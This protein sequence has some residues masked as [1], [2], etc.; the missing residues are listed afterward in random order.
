MRGARSLVPGLAVGLTTQFG[1]VTAIAERPV[2]LTDSQLEQITAAGSFSF[3]EAFAQG[4]G[5]PTASTTFTDTTITALVGG[6]SAFGSAEALAVGADVSASDAV[7]QV[8]IDTNPGAHVVDATAHGVGR[9]MQISYAET[10]GIATLSP[11]E[12][13]AMG[14]AYGIGDPSTTSSLTAIETNAG[15]GT[16]EAVGM[17]D[18]LGSDGSPNMSLTAVQLTPGERGGGGGSTAGAVGGDQASSMSMLAMSGNGGGASAMELSAVAAAIAAGNATTKTQASATMTSGGSV[19]AGVAAAEASATG[20][21][22][23]ETFAAT[24]GSASGGNI[25]RTVTVKTGH[26]NGTMSTMKSHTTVTS[27]TFP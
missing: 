23:H 2:L 11:D 20:N 13:S 15:A 1:S 6:A 17:A 12:V 18:A 10:V 9:P 19:N 3:S 7:T 24:H 8:R 21:D 26:G 5:D 16:Y 25:T 22:L 4:V 27:T 14:L